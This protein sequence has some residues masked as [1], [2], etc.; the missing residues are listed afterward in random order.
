MRNVRGGAPNPVRY[1]LGYVSVRI[2]VFSGRK[3][4]RGPPRNNQP[5][6]CG[7]GNPRETGLLFLM[8]GGP[9]RCVPNN[10]V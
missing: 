5:T 6:T 3:T 2:F 9:A 8:E 7:K 4:E 10:P 1:F